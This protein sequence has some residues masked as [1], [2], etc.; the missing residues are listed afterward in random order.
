M[1]L[2]FLLLVLSLSPFCWS[3]QIGQGFTQNPYSDS[4]Y[5]KPNQT[6]LNANVKLKKIPG[7]EFKVDSLH[8]GTD[9]S[10]SQKHD[11]KMGYNFNSPIGLLNI[12]AN[13]T[14]LPGYMDDK[15]S[16][17]ASYLFKSKWSSFSFS[18]ENNNNLDTKTNKFS[19]PIIRV[20]GSFIL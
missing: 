1:K 16:L 12:S 11:L 4:Y 14:K 19:D 8:T 18:Y 15:K 13:N 10:Q 6:L 20:S 17:S 2:P 9:L 5:I 3:Q 7:F